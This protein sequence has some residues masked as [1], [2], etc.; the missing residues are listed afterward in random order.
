METHFV[1]A[2]GYNYISLVDL[3]SCAEDRLRSFIFKRMKKYK[4]K[5]VMVT[6]IQLWRWRLITKEKMENYCQGNEYVKKSVNDDLETL[7]KNVRLGKEQDDY[8]HA[9]FLPKLTKEEMKLVERKDYN[10][11]NTFSSQM[12]ADVNKTEMMLSESISKFVR[13]HS[14]RFTFTIENESKDSKPKTFDRCDLQ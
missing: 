7:F 1:Y 10:F 5:K 6:C 9:Y 12:D 2:D 8:V 11:M 14:E 3:K 4:I 13:G